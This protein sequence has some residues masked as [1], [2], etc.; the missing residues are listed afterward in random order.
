MTINVTPTPKLPWD[1]DIIATVSY[2]NRTWI[3]TARDD[4]YHPFVVHEL[5][6]DGG[7]YRGDYCVDRPR[8]YAAMM[9]RVTGLYPD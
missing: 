4:E 7:C 3:V 9:E 5:M 6:P 8:A 1:Y 2:A